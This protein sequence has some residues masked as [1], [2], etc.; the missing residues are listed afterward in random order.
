[1]KRKTIIDLIKAHY[2]N[3]GALFFNLT[4]EVLK[5]FKQEQ[6][7]KELSEY[8]ES[9]ILPHITVVPKR[10]VDT[11]NASMSEKELSEAFFFVPQSDNV[12]KERGE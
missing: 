9:L 4:L 3:D 7:C 8:V 5:E 1:M 10:D 2:E 12:N 6:D 11:F